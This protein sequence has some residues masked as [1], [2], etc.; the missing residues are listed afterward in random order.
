MVKKNMYKKIKHFK[1]QGF[2]KAEIIAM[3][4]RLAGM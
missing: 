3:E 4:K 1:K 2:A